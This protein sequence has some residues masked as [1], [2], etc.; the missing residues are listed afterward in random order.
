MFFAA[1]MKF[2]G[3][4][5]VSTAAHLILTRPWAATKSFNGKQ[6]EPRPNG[7][8]ANCI[9]STS[10]APRW[11]AVKRSRMRAPCAHH[12]PSD[13]NF[14]ETHELKTAL[15]CRPE[16]KA[17]R[18]PQSSQEN[19]HDSA[20]A[21][22]VPEPR[23][24]VAP[25]VPANQRPGRRRNRVGR[26]V[27]PRVH[28]AEDNTIRLALIGCGGRGS[29]AVRDALD[30]SDGPVKLHA[31]ADVQPGRLAV[32]LKALENRFPDLIDVPAERQFVGFDAYKKAIDSLRPGDVAMLTGYV[33]WR[34]VQLEYA[35]E[36]GVNVFMEK[37]FGCDRP[38]CGG[39]LPRATRRRRRT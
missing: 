31:M 21:S 39:S 27:V 6:I 10:R 35:I 26:A 13:S 29:G 22:V 25:S 23:P 3:L 15:A 17:F 24:S 18:I 28:A 9:A 7:E 12:T 16:Q 1:K 37:S 4:T 14:R 36:K 2:E 33:G 5:S 38:P 8:R 19:R 32:S 30:A 11:V 20:T 34:P